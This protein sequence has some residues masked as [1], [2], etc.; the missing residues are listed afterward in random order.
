VLGLNISRLVSR[1]RTLWPD[2]LLGPDALA[3]AQRV[4]W[5]TWNPLK[6]DSLLLPSSLL[7]PV[8]IVAEGERDKQ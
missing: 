4:T 3:Q 2:R 7:G 1:H 8:R 5:T 6:K